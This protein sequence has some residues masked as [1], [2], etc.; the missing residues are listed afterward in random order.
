MCYKY[1]ILHD[2]N[3]LNYPPPD[4]HYCS[5][6][7][8]LIGT[9]GCY[10]YT[11]DLI[12]LHSASYTQSG[13][14]DCRLAHVHTPLNITEWQA[15]LKRHPD[16]DFTTYVLSGL[17]DSFRIGVR[18]FH[19]LQYAKRNKHLASQNPQVINDYLEEEREAGNILG[20]ISQPTFKSLWPRNTN[21]R[22][23]ASLLI[24]GSPTR[25]V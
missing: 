25:L 17:Q 15:C 9:D 10:A 12:A 19:H 8:N 3:C 21:L 23:R 11:A 16:T 6:N 13:P 14:I 7:Y 4:V 1:Y 18:A 22:N 2:N 5:H 24:S 20:P